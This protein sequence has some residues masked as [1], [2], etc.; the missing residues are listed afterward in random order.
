MEFYSNLEE[1]TTI[2]DAM[3][4]FV[5]L[6]KI[7]E[8]SLRY[9]YANDAAKRIRKH[10]NIIGSMIENVLP[11]RAADFLIE[12]YH[13][14]ANTKKK[15]LFEDTFYSQSGLIIGETSLN[16]L[17]SEDGL[18]RYVVGITRDIT[19]RRKQEAV[20]KEAKRKHI[21]TNKRLQSLVN[22]NNEGVFELDLTGHFLSINDKALEI[23][24]FQR[25]DV[26]GMSFQSFITNDDKE[27]VQGH[28]QNAL[29]G[30]NRE[31]EAWVY[32][33]NGDKVLVEI[34]GIPIIVDDQLEGIYCIVN[35]ITEK[36]RLKFLLEEREQK[37]RSLFEH[38]P[39]PIFTLNREGVVVAGNRST[40]KITGN[41]IENYVGKSFMEFLFPEDMKKAV[42]YFEKSIKERSAQTYEI[43]FQHENGQIKDI[44]ITNVPIIV[45]H[46]IIGVY[47]LTKDITEERLYQRV[48]YE[49]K[50]ELE[51]FWNYT[52]DPIF[53]FSEGRMVK[54]NPAFEQMF[55]FT[56]AEVR[57]EGKNL[58]IPYEYSDDPM[59]ISER[60]RSG[61]IITLF[62]TKRKT[63][64]GELLDIIATYTPIKNA[65]GA[66]IGGTAF[67]KDVTEYKD[68]QRELLKAEEKFRL[69]TENAFDGIKVLNR[70]GIV[71]Y[72]SPSY[73]K[74]M[75]YSPA[76]L[77]NEPFDKYS[78]RESLHHLIQEF[79]A[80]VRGKENTP[81][82]ARLK[83]KNG[84]WKW[85][86][87]TLA[88]IEEGNEINQ[89]V[90]I[91]RDITEKKKQQQVLEKLAF[92][93][94]LTGLPNRR[95]FDDT[96]TEALIDAKNNSKQI[97]VMMLDGLRF[98][99]IN[100]SF[101]H[102]AGDEV[103]R[104]L[105]RRVQGCV[106]KTDVVARF[107]GDELGII[108]RELDSEKR[109]IGIA[110]RIIMALH[111]PLY[112]NGHIIEFGVGIGISFYPEHGQ[113]KKELIKLA[114]N[115]LYE[116]KGLKV[117]SYKV[118]RV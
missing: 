92:H 23:T 117:S 30:R 108:V 42:H 86:E 50:E 49:T 33:Y 62:E 61:E 88:P 69:I 81:L 44:L 28:F 107:G 20:L 3:D 63:K 76:E 118:Y 115:A 106:R 64:T 24:G 57:E 98:K 67:Y 77:V 22:H 47:G 21:R 9:L 70:K 6:M 4:D 38:H 15:V 75:G 100:D 18:C 97:A 91:A 73:E 105:A 78:D 65:E 114:D 103:I 85:V 110:E 84:H 36:R 79:R 90:C 41:S 71:E 93:D 66:I 2:F 17:E 14:A 43:S 35:D 48:L 52:A 56:E 68:A 11:K 96:L 25:E 26:I 72:A 102:D 53:L 55:G 19:E 87:I 40:E 27:E 101:G 13:E 10:N 111:K 99:E 46:E 31:L 60:I 95:V 59:E 16:P 58:T 45:D 89:V 113:S 74:I 34:K 8:N 32:K 116:A 112:Y 37:Y 83:H 5:F 80:V 104:E 39:D 29:L 82:E 12:K 7:E 54:V 109:A 94:Y 51:S 1:L